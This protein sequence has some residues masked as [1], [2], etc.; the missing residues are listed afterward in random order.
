MSGNC[1]LV[2][3]ELDSDAML[4]KS[5]LENHHVFCIAG[6][7]LDHSDHLIVLKQLLQFLLQD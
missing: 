4:V 7:V 2:G 3:D 1:Y 6:I 5:V